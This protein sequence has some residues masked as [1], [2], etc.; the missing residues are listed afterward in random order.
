[1]QCDSGF[2]DLETMLIFATEEAL[3]DWTTFGSWACGGTFECS[4]L[5]FYQI[6]TLHIVISEWQLTD[7]KRTGPNFVV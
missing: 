3:K 6:F 1:M 7:V 2:N 5:N 4:S